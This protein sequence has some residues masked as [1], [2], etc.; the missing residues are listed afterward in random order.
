[1]KKKVMLRLKRVIVKL[2]KRLGTHTIQKIK[3]N[4]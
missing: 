3:A 1:M 2:I 4:Y